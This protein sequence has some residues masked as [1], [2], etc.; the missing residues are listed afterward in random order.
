VIGDD[1][2]DLLTEFRN[3]EVRFLVIG[4]HAMAVHGFPRATQDLD[5]W[6]DPTQPN[7]TRAI[8][9]LARFGAP[10]DA[11]GVTMQ[12]LG[13]PGVVVQL[14]LPPNRIDLRTAISGVEDFESAWRGRS[15][16]LIRGLAVPFLDRA[17]LR[18]NKR[19][20]GRLKDLADLETLGDAD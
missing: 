1:W 11:L 4:A 12:D 18:A 9:A 19:A 5:L 13:T 17:R 15:E 8:E 10:I 3:A 20:S 2:F 6:L 14:G 16:H 7:A